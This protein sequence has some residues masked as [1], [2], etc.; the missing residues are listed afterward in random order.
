[1]FRLR[2]HFQPGRGM[3]RACVVSGRWL[4]AG[5]LSLAAT[6]ARAGETLESF[7]PLTALVML[8]LLGSFT[9]HL[10]LYPD[11]LRSPY[12]KPVILL[13]LGSI[14]LTLLWSTVARTHPGLALLG[15]AAILTVTLFTLNHWVR[16]A[17]FHTVKQL[18]LQ[19]V[20]EKTSSLQDIHSELTSTRE[21][22]LAANQEL[23]TLTYVDPVTGLYPR[24]YFNRQLLYEWHSARR[25]QHPL[26]LIMVAV[27]H[28]QELQQHGESACQ[29]ILRSLAGMLQDQFQRGS[30]TLCRIED[31]TF[32]VLLPN[33]L[34]GHALELADQ[35]R[36]KVARRPPANH[37]EAPRVSASLGVGGLIPRQDQYP[38]VLFAAVEQALARVIRDGSNGC[39]L[40]NGYPSAPRANQARSQPSSTGR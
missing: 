32:A 20:A 2:R 31:N 38:A 29:E 12:R 30:D 7:P 21:A 24:P 34:P 22:L 6:G 8:T 27:D 16:Q 26:S 37:P 40:A 10:F 4:L 15:F 1:M 25:E 18:L 14:P 36:Q 3:T 13:A 35:L 5:L 23:Q 28:W 9:L 19:E 33:T 17:G 11:V 39:Q